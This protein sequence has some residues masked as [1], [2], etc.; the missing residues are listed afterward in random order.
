M[1]RKFTCT[2]I[3]LQ[4]LEIDLQNIYAGIEV[5]IRSDMPE[6]GADGKF[7]VNVPPKQFTTVTFKTGESIKKEYKEEVT[8]E[9]K[10]PANTTM[11]VKVSGNK[12]EASAQFTAMMKRVYYDDSENT[13]AIT[14]S[15]R[16]EA[17]RGVEVSYTG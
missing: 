4:S 12:Y 6:L 15:Y 3:Q 1:T 10:L 17:V 13:V 5:E 11:T 14:G 8:A 2:T 16:V 7:T 9:L